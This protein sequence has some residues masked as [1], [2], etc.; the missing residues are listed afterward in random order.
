MIQGEF[1]RGWRYKN[2]L[3]FAV[4]LLLFFL[5]ADTHAVQSMI[6]RIG[7]WGYAGAFLAGIF[8]VSTFTVVPAIYVIF[9]LADLLNPF[10]IAIFAGLGSVLGDLVIFRLTR[11]VL[12]EEWRPIFSKL[13]GSYLGKVFQTPFFAWLTPLAGAAI[14]ASPLPD[15]IGAGICGISR[16]RT[17][18]FMLLSFL[19]NATGIFLTVTIARL[20]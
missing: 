18:Q 5:I 10:S 15:E 20:V 12:L 14:I 17:W 9:S 8:F 11:D 2:T 16:L 1:F 3:L 4:G 6:Y 13:G 19:L 7:S